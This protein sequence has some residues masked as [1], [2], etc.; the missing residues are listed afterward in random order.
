MITNNDINSSHVH[1]HKTVETV[2]YFC[3]TVSEYET[4]YNANEIST[5]TITLIAEDRSIR[6][7]G[8]KYGTIDLETFL[9][10]L[11]ECL[12]AIKADKNLYGVI[13]L[14]QYLKIDNDGSTNVD[15][16][17]LIKDPDLIAFLNRF[18]VDNPTKLPIATYS[19]LGV[20]KVGSGLSITNDGTLS[21]KTTSNPGDPNQGIKQI[22]L[23]LVRNDSDFRGSDQ[24]FG[25]F[26]AGAGLSAA[27]GVLSVNY[28]TL[29]IPGYKIQNGTLSN[30]ILTINQENNTDVS[31]DLSGLV[32]NV[33]T[34]IQFR[35]VDGAL[36]VSYDGGRTW[37][38]LGTVKGDP[39]QDGK[40]GKDGANG[41]NGADGK[42][43]KDGQDGSIN[44]T[45]ITNQIINEIKTQI[46]DENNYWNS[47]VSDQ[48]N[49]AISTLADDL[50]NNW[51]EIQHSSGWVDA[52]NAYLQQIGL[53]TLTD[54]PN[55]TTT[56]VDKYSTLEQTLNSIQTQVTQL[57]GLFSNNGQLI[58][59]E[60]ALTQILS[61]VTG[62]EAFNQA[63]ATII[64]QNYGT[65]ATTTSAISSL[66]Q[67]ASNT[68]G[69]LEAVSKMTTRV[70]T[71]HNIT[72]NLLKSV[73]NKDEAR[74]SLSTSYGIYEMND[75]RYEYVTDDN[76]D[77]VWE[78]DTKGHAI[79]WTT[80]ELWY[81]KEDGTPTQ[82]ENQGR[83]KTNTKLVE[84]QWVTETVLDNSGNPVKDRIGR[85]A[86]FRADAQTGDYSPVIFGYE[87]EMFTN[88]EPV[89]NGIFLD[90][91]AKHADYG[92]YRVAYHRVRKMR[93]IS[94]ADF[95]LQADANGA[96]ASLSANYENWENNSGAL[97]SLEQE[98]HKDSARIKNFAQLS[99]FEAKEFDV[100][101]QNGYTTKVIKF[102]CVNKNDD[103]DKR[104]FEDDQ[105]PSQYVKIIKSDVY[106]GIESSV[107]ASAAITN[108]TSRMSGVEAGIN[109][110]VKK[111]EQGV[112]ESGVTINADKINIDANHQLDLSAQQ[113]NITAEQ[114][115]AAASDLTVKSLSARS[116]NSTV[117][118]NAN[119]IQIKPTSNTV[120]VSLNNDG[121]GHL[122]NGNVSWN[123]DGVCQFKGGISAES[124]NI[125]GQLQIQ[126]QGSLY[127]A[128]TCIDSTGMAGI[129]FSTYVN[130][131]ESNYSIPSV[132]SPLIINTVNDAELVLPPNP[133][134][135]Q[136]FIIC[137]M[138]NCT[139]RVS[140]HYHWIS[141]L[142]DLT[143]N[144]GSLGL[145][146]GTTIWI[147]FMGSITS[148]SI[149]N[150]TRDI[151]AVI[152]HNAV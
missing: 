45:Q 129:N 39:G 34:N 32:S 12:S 26:K 47:W 144:S 75:G 77:P 87:D 123:T 78:L 69:A 55:G 124:G 113:I 65:V 28:N 71:G 64:T 135:G 38:S 131:S 142:N 109:L 35:I 99:F 151:W 150:N 146:A 73:A 149:N 137:T 66:E 90:G 134:Q 63:I 94:L 84:G 74:T 101:D 85:I 107:D 62:S 91:S 6:R 82:Y 7:N 21:V 59:L 23:D 98:V 121:S 88:G 53:I 9:S 103:T 127:C 141:S 13:K 58:T 24:R 120:S 100:T 67:R 110:S 112:I 93:T 108:L 114:I 46:T 126:D 49:I 122:A 115:Q 3:P 8:I 105:I 104:W 4:L 17:E 52:L 5:R 11:L 60:E 130:S 68:N 72:L 152:S 1:D 51:G 132:L 29:N 140:N 117:T 40:D 119:G 22:V 111:N 138:Q 37:S 102:Y 41:Q 44:S 31:V 125:K 56:I 145:G 30:N 136:T 81:V 143:D 18:Y 118:A 76:N 19:D 147:M 15:I 128:G 50:K 96:L 43:G 97:A 27:N 95:D 148:A 61:M 116:N 48:I 80:L 54:N 25:V 36:Q 14:G 133:A 33:E 42:D 139:L 83:N 16:E 86:Y 106:A 89:W 70:D 79:P 92:Q 20:I 57:T 2:F 10:M